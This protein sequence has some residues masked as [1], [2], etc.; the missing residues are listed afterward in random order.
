MA[1][2]NGITQTPLRFNDQ[3]LA[4]AAQRRVKFA[5]ADDAAYDLAIVALENAPATTPAGVKA[6]FD[7]YSL[8]VES[9]RA[10]DDVSP[11]IMATLERNIAGGLAH[12]ARKAG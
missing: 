8:R 1:K 5:G 12:L 6:L 4:V 2:H 9:L 10:G 3:D 7:L 11:E